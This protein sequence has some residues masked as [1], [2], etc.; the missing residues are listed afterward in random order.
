MKLVNPVNLIIINEN[1]Q[2]LLCKRAANDE[3]QAN[4]WSI[5]GGCAE[6][7]EC[8][9]KALQR[10]IK[11]ELGCNIK[12]LNYF[13]SYYFQINK[14]KAARAVYFYGSISKN[15]KLNHELSEFNWFDLNDSEMLQ[16]NLAFYQKKVIKDFVGSW[17]YK[18][19]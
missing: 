11:E 8:F 16:L 10:E 13:G 19:N 14:T 4:A 3:A 7:G 2:I 9:E 18:K 17:S 5:P 1:E 12:E 15:I 6:E